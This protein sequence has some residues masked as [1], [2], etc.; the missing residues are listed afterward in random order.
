MK[1]TKIM[2]VRACLNPSEHYIHSFFPGNM[3]RNFLQELFQ[4]ITLLLWIESLGDG[5]QKQDRQI[6]ISDGRTE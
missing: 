5:Y 6:K 1:I 2:R 4:E 3:T